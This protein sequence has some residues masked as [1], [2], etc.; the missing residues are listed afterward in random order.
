MM[1]ESSDWVKR[2]IEA[3]Q[4]HRQTLETFI[5]A[6]QLIISA[7]HEQMTSDI[8]AFQEQF[9][10]EHIDLFVDERKQIVRASRTF[11]SITVHS[12]VYIDPM[13]NS[14][15]WKLTPSEQDHGEFPLVMQEGILSLIAS[16]ESQVTQR[17]LSPL[18]FPRLASDSVVNNIFYDEFRPKE[19]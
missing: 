11:G 10:T 9:P 19:I 17:I 5:K 12:D 1:A 6:G 7:L 4:R 8:A 13:R 14:L 3:D 15:I 18:F 2:F 16:S